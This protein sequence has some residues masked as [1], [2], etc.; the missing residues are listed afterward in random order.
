MKKT[1]LTVIII[2]FLLSMLFSCESREDISV[3]PLD[4]KDKIETGE[5]QKK[6]TKY[7]KSYLLLPESGEEIEID[8]E[9]LALAEGI[10][11]TLLVKAE[12]SLL[13]EA[14]NYKGE[15]TFYLDVDEEE[16]LLLCMEL[17]VELTPTVNEEGDVEDH[18]H[19]F[20]KK[21]I[22]K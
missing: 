12:R 8:E 14:A 6:G 17:V 16:G 9:Y 19:L 18:T 2:S 10:D 20:Y 4:T 21:A 5:E 11:D 15:R 1:F 3:E 7:I 22:T 13:S